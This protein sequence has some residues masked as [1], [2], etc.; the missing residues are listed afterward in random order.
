MAP[1]TSVGVPTEIILDELYPE[2]DVRK[3]LSGSD[4]LFDVSKERE[5]VDWQSEHTW[6]EL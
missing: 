2:T 3:P 6:R 4:G 5:L 1:D